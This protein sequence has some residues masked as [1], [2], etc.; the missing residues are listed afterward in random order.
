M[1]TLSVPPDCYTCLLAWEWK[2]FL[3]CPIAHPDRRPDVCRGSK[4]QVYDL[5]GNQVVALDVPANVYVF[6]GL[7]P[8]V[9]CQVYGSGWQDAAE[10]SIAYAG[11][12]GLFALQEQHLADG[13][14]PGCGWLGPF[15]L[16]SP[17]WEPRDRQVRRYMEAM[18][19]TFSPIVW[20]GPSVNAILMNPGLAGELHRVLW[21]AAVHANYKPAL[22]QIEPF[23]W[24]EFIK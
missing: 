7:L 20:I 8:R 22:T 16:R 24:S 13:C 21:A 3:G 23:D 2:H 19:R 11:Y 6:G 9:C 1:Y 17:D 4:W 5:G 12:P 14:L 15:S 10:Q 18:T